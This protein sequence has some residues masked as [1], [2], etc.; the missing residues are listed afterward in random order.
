MAS[1]KEAKNAEMHLRTHQLQLTTYAV[2]HESFDSGHSPI[3]VGHDQF[4]NS[5]CVVLVVAPTTVPLPAGAN[6][7]CELAS[8][9]VGE[10]SEKYGPLICRSGLLVR[11]INHTQPMLTNK[12]PMSYSD[13]HYSRRSLRIARTL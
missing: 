6:I 8:Q 2:A 10:Q 4:T 12:L 7:S 3:P 9:A 13:L 11:A 1:T 5:R